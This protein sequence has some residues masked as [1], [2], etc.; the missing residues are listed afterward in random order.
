MVNP[1]ALRAGSLDHGIAMRMGL[2]Y[3]VLDVG[4]GADLGVAALCKAAVLR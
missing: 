1:E 2:A 3:D 4:E